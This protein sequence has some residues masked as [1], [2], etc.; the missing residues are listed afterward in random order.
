M[1][2]FSSVLLRDI[3]LK[4]R[5]IVSPMCQYSAKEGHPQTWHLAHL[6]SRAVGGASL[7][8]TEA[9]AVEA[10]RKNFAC[11]YGNLRRRSRGE[12]ASDCGVHPRA[13]R[14]RRKAV[15]PCGTERQHGCSLEG[16]QANTT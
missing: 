6:G 12:L 1:K 15:G 2:L 9:T 7:V 13:G 5:I 8:F 3:E 11:G 14:N 10:P 4:N 16:R